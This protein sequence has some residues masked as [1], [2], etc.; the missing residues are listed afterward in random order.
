MQVPVHISFQEMEASEAV[1]AAIKDKVAKL[2][3]IFNRI[4]SCKVT[5]AIPHRHQHQGNHF[6]VRIDLSVPGAE[7]VV[8][9]DPVNR[10]S[11]EDCYVAIH[12]AFNAAKKQLKTYADK[13]FK[14]HLHH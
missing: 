9:R 12:E 7:L 14:N 10:A 3:K 6:N 1:E 11:H 13:H 8:N 5:V 4:T 2:E